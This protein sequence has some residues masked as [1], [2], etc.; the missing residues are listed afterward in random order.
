MQAK[1]YVK[2]TYTPTTSQR[3]CCALVRELSNAEPGEGGGGVS[4]WPTAF[5]HPVQLT[6]PTDPSS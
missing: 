3:E 2:L 4:G 6:R 1:P 5:A